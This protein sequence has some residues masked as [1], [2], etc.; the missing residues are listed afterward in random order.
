MRI[1]TTLLILQIFVPAAFGQE[2]SGKISGRV[3]DASGKPMD[4]V[5][6]SLLKKADSATT[7]L[8][9]T[10]KSGQFKFENIATGKYILSVTHIGYANWYSQPLEITT[11]KPSISVNTI[12]LRSSDASLTQVTVVGKRPLIENKIDKTVV[13]VDASTTNGGLTALEVLHKSPAV[14]VD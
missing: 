4:A 13:N 9:I 11:S 5:S 2:T 7:K 3:E 6:V 12:S 10:D 14:M 1:L 8:A